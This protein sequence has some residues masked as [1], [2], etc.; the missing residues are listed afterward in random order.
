METWLRISYYLDK[1]RNIFFSQK[2]VK[3]IVLI[4]FDLKS[5]NVIFMNISPL[6]FQGLIARCVDLAESQPNHL[7]II[8]NAEGFEHWDFEVLQTF[9]PQYA[10]RRRL[11]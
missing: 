5:L 8:M 9:L 6:L 10:K 1:P 2:K 3:E 4:V 11:N 7:E